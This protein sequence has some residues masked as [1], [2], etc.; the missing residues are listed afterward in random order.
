MAFQDTLTKVTIRE[1]IGDEGETRQRQLI[2]ASFRGVSFF[3]NSSGRTGGRRVLSHE[4]P[5][6][7][8]NTVE[9]LGRRRRPYR[10]EGYVLGRDY[11][12]KRDDLLDV[13]ENRS[14]PGEL[15]HPYFG[16]I[17]AVCT[18]VSVNETTSNGGQATFSLEF[19]EVQQAPI[20]PVEQA[21]RA[22]AVTDSANTAQTQTETEFSDTYDSLNEPAYAVASL[23]D[24]LVARTEGLRESLGRVVEATQELAALDLEVQTLVGE[25]S[26]LIRSPTA[27]I[28]AFLDVLA[29]VTETAADAPGDVLN[30]LL[31]AY[32][33]AEQT[34]AIGDTDIR[35]RERANQQAL[36]GVL[37][38][39]LA[40]DAAR[41]IPSVQF[42]TL[43]D[44]TTVRG[45][46]LD[47]LGEQAADADDQTYGDIQD[48]RAAV[49]LAVPGENAL[50]R[51][52]TFNQA[53]S[54]PSLLLT[55]RLYGSVE[56]ETEVLER[57]VVADPAFIF[58]D[59]E[60]LSQ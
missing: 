15:V 44:A 5:L 50:A 51:L 52:I 45:Q 46:V 49:A 3:V 48:L 54:V 59:L 32:N 58:G 21:D 24:E 41:L 6:R 11:K 57:N 60:V 42:E 10:V 55:F 36:A 39:T 9:D 29:T 18:S 56:R 26:T 43:D 47:A 25:A 20:T 16:S 19:L 40:I 23:T 1:A 38:R 22:A 37:K 12:Q 35:I 28:A 27:T 31:E 7:D 4:Y 34:L 33:V 14:G 30:A 2:G 13:L 17:Q 53:V 8:E